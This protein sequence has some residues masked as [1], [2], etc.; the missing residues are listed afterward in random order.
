[1]EYF[2][3]RHKPDNSLAPPRLPSIDT[4]QGTADLDGKNSW[5]IEEERA[6]MKAADV[7]AT[8]V[9]SVLF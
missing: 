9:I 7:M 5:R 2:Q 4:H 1:L 8:N 6:P 3:K